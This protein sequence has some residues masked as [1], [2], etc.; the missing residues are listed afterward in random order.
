M[1]NK[2]FK[3]PSPTLDDKRFD[4]DKDGKLN[5]TETMFRD[6]HLDEMSRK[7]INS[8]I[9]QDKKYK[10]NKSFSIAY[11][12]GGVFVGLV[13]I[14]AV[15]PAAILGVCFLLLSFSSEKK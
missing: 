6:M 12:L 5:I 11:V 8:C 14:I 13:A 4:A 10:P 7:D 9:D 3:Y 2:S 1:R 15:I